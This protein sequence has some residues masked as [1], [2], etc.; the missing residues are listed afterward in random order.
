M[1]RLKNRCDHAEF[2]S[3]ITEGA[4]PA[5]AKSPRKNCRSRYRKQFQHALDFRDMLS[6]VFLM[7]L[8]DD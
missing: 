1:L 4:S 3:E 8:P 7:M 6:I 5:M 2:A